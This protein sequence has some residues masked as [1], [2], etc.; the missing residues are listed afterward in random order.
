L[1]VG[2]IKEMSKITVPDA[3]DPCIM[4]TLVDL[5]EV[6]E[7]VKAKACHIYTTPTARKH[8]CLTPE[9]CGLSRYY[10]EL[11][12]VGEGDATTWTLPSARYHRDRFG[13][14]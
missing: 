2:S 3:F 12:T 1:K 6:L 10:E 5:G 8:P 11:A 14:P 13:T 9:A 7:K 4:H